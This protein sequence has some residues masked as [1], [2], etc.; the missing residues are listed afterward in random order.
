MLSWVQQSFLKKIGELS[1]LWRVI[2]PLRQKTIA[3]MGHPS[4]LFLSNTYGT[5]EAVAFQNQTLTTG[6]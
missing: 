4:S 6:C 5:D 2:P 3:R 1:T